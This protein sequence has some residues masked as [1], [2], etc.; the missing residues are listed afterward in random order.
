MLFIHYLGKQDQ[1]WA[2]NAFHSQ[3]YALP[4]TYEHW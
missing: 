1:I 2:K 4:Y 3:K